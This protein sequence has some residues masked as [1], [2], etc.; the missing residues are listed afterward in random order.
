MAP[1]GAL[2]TVTLEVTYVTPLVI[3]NAALD[4]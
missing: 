2:I 3:V 4:I 1:V